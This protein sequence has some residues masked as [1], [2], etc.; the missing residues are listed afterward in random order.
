VL[1]SGEDDR[2]VQ[3]VARLAQAHRLRV[4]G[5]LRK[6]V[7]LRRLR[8][9]LAGLRQAAADTVRRPLRRTYD[10]AQLRQA[11]CGRQLVVHY[12]PQVALADASLVGVEALVRWKHPSLGL[13]HPEQFIAD[14]EAS[15]LIDALTDFVLGTALADARRWRDAGLALR[16]SVNVSIDNLQSLDFPDRVVRQTREADIAPE[17]LVLEI[18]ESHAMR[19]PIALL[20]IAARL[21]LKHLGLSIDDFGI[22]HSSLQRLRDIPF[23]ELK[24]DRG[25]VHGAAQ[26]P[27]LR[28]ILRAN[29]ALAR[30]LGLRT[31]AE[32][33]EDRADWGCLRA[34]GCDLAQG[35]FIARPMP[36]TDL[37]AWAHAWR[38]GREA[39][40]RS[41]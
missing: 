4:A 11:V 27:R 1:V 14:V 12:Q 41:A 13:V 35:W 40:R 2:V 33:V 21:R 16:M 5:T 15:G 26:E 6:P 20:D 25:F 34:L 38:A 22:G 31:V 19:D 30:Q 7:P 39:L 3:S 9:L 36:A 28:A 18:T 29:L 10:A 17:E 37:A 24:L 23:D 8:A 32:G